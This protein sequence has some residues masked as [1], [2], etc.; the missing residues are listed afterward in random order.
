MK[1]IVITD[2][3]DVLLVNI[4]GG[5]QQRHITRKEYGIS[6]CAEGK[7]VYEHDGKSF[8]SDPQH[9]MIL[10]RNLSYTIHEIHPGHF[11]VINFTCTDDC[12]IDDFISCEVDSMN[13]FMNSYE[14]I[15]KLFL[16]KRD[17]YHL[18]ALSSLYDMLGNLGVRDYQSREYHLITAGIRYMEENFS[19]PLMSVEKMAEVSGMSV[20]Y[21]RRMFESVYGT[22]PRKYLIAIRIKKAK[23]LLNVNRPSIQEVAAQCGF[24]SVHHFCRCFK[25]EV[26]CTATEYFEQY[27]IKGI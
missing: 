12:R 25:D 16:F 26:G 15:Q 21:Y 23:Q 3:T 13:V 11:P 27:G 4:I 19:D 24:S 20:A 5:N 1:D 2:V 8:V 9:V 14:Y 18:K 17:N 6:F 22:S 7:I 10:P